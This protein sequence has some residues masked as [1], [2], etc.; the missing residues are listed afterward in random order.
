MAADK[1]ANLR[2][3]GDRGNRYTG[4]KTYKH[5]LAKRR[6]QALVATNTDIAS[7]KTTKA[8]AL[9]RPLP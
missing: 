3:G 4:G 5:G 1:L 9:W 2:H 7:P 6:G 8:P